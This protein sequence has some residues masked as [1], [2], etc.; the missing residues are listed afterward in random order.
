MTPQQWKDL[1]HSDQLLR[2]NSDNRKKREKHHRWR[3]RDQPAYNHETDSQLETTQYHRNINELTRLVINK[4]SS[5]NFMKKN[6]RITAD[7]TITNVFDYLNLKWQ[8]IKFYR[9]VKTKSRNIPNE[10]SPELWSC[11]GKVD[12]THQIPSRRQTHPTLHEQSVYCQ[13]KSFNAHLSSAMFTTNNK[14]KSQNWESYRQQES[15]PALWIPNISL[16][17]T[18]PVEKQFMPLIIND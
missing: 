6:I 12:W 3:R 2:M 11:I 1:L 17:K 13:L 4:H 9:Q 16:W 7:D 18:G 8:K 5:S 15:H 14:K 10:R